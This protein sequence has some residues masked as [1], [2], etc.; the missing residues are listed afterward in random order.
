MRK[1]NF[2]IYVVLFFTIFSSCDQN[3]SNNLPTTS[4][5]YDFENPITT[6]LPEELA[7]ISGIAFYPKDSSIF[8]IIDEDGILFKVSLNKITQIKKWKFDKKRDFE[9]IILHDSIFYVLV[10]NGDIETIQFNERD[11]IIT[12]LSKFPDADKKTN[13]FE[14]LYFDDSL[15]QIILLCKNC[16]GDG[17]KTATA[18]GY[19]INAKNY[20][21]SVYT[22]DV[23][24]LAK[25]LKEEKI[26]LRASATAI[27]PITNDVYILSSIN[28]II[29]V[30]DRQ[31]NFKTLYNLDPTIYKQ[32]EGIA[33]TAWGDMLVSNEWKETGSANI[34]I[35][36]NKQKGL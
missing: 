34:L 7:E 25:K 22:I 23:S 24:S 18:W 5:R 6:K 10:S 21:A 11:S 32:P 9:D 3:K 19:D 30:T 2:L 13:E 12:T 15:K 1:N 35:I 27:N 14:S 17:S 20:S 8:A 33:F 26:K 29:L 4:D 31:G 36:K 16:E 28:H